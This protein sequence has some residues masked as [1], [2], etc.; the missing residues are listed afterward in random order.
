MAEIGSGIGERSVEIEK[1]GLDHGKVTARSLRESG[2][3]GECW[4]NRE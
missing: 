1:N 2:S 3:A 4:I